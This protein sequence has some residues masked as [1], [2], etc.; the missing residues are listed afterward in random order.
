MK[1]T[2]EEGIVVEIQGDLA[3]VKAMRHGDCKNCGACPSDDA[4]VL[5][6]RNPIEAKPG[7]KV[8]FEMKQDNM[9][10][11]AF[12][13]YILPLVAIFIGV[14]LGY[15]VSLYTGLNEILCQILGVGISIAISVIAIK[16]Y[17]TLTAKNINSLPVIK[18]IML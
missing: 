10:K 5:M 6:V 17:D 3:K 2:V 18:N 1:L 4:T 16:K 15:Y 9:L 11:A 7:Q 13:V 14:G 12:V 8:S